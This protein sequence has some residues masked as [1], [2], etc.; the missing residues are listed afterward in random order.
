MKQRE[1]WIDNLRGF[2]IVL[3][4]LGHVI[5][6][7]HPQYEDTIAFRYIYSFHMPLFVFIS[8]LVCGYLN[9]GG[10]KLIIKRFYQLIVPFMVYCLIFAII[11][12]DIR[13]S[14]DYLVHP[15]KRLWFLWVLFF[16]TLFQQFGVYIAKLT[17]IKEWLIQIVLGIILFAVGAKFR[18]FCM[19]DIAKFFVFYTLAYYTGS[20]IIKIK[21]SKSIALC[22]TISVI[23]FLVLAY[24]CD[25]P[26]PEHVP[27]TDIV[28]SGG[29]SKIYKMMVAFIG[30][31]AFL[32]VFRMFVNKNIKMLTQ[33]G[34]KD[35]LGIYAIHMVLL[36]CIPFKKFLT[37]LFEQ[38]LFIY[39][40]ISVFVAT[41]GLL[42]LSIGL[43]WCFRK[44][45]ITS[46]LLL[47]ENHK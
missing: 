35:T 26:Y 18:L 15:E 34:I 12:G 7:T 3:V 19:P 25:F 33:I 4:V 5:Q 46:L 20:S 10:R 8:G 2:L 6:G 21:F 37:P 42:A 45:S 47:G 14:V 27:F 41:I 1:L 31:T 36:S 43:I 30:I 39:Y 9:G 23:L 22:T 29:L 32:L 38:G 24:W 40:W 28:L 17:R 44:T 16:V 13:L 11:A